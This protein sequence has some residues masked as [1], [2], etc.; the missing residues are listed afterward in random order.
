M[1]HDVSLSLHT[2]SGMTTYRILEPGPYWPDTGQAHMTCITSSVLLAFAESL[3]VFLIDKILD[4][5]VGS[6]AGMV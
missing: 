6:S 3:V 1:E 5:K 4:N 2:T